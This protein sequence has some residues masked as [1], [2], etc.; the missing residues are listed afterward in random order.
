MRFYS[1]NF[2]YPI[3]RV[4]PSWD[5]V[6]AGLLKINSCFSFAKMIKGPFI[7]SQIMRVAYVYRR[8]LSPP[9]FR[10]FTTHR[11]KLSVK[12]IRVK[13]FYA[14]FIVINR[15]VPVTTQTRYLVGIP[16]N[17]KTILPD[18]PPIPVIVKSIFIGRGEIEM[19]G[20]I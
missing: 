11:F 15:S 17:G 10:F 5:L 7:I 6:Y 18:F 9:T 13:C 16:M 19:R 20:M 2:L 4:F 3:K 8:V 1:T 14:F 12:V